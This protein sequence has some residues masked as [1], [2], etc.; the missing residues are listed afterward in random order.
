MQELDR[1]AGL[2][3]AERMILVTSGGCA[4][5]KSYALEKISAV[6]ALKDK[7]AAVWDAA[8][9]QNATENPW[10]LDEAE[11]RGINVGFVYVHADPAAIWADEKR[12][13]AERAL[14]KGRMIDAYVFADSHLMGAKNFDSFREKNGDRAAFFVVDNSGKDGPRLVD[15]VPKTTWSREKLVRYCQKTLVEKK[16]K[17]TPSILRGGLVGERYWRK[18][19]RRG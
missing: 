16:S 2:P 1:I 8:G 6:G 17:L 10:V 18:E 15:K 14:S 5:G 19:F 9:D 13:V 12:G 4:A 7:A 11:K 3:E